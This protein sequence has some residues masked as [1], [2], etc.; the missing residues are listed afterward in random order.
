MVDVMDNDETMG[1]AFGTLA[2]QFVRNYVTPEIDAYR[3][4]KYAETSGISAATPPT[5]PL[6]PRTCPP[7]FR[8]PRAP[9]ATTRFPRRAEILFISENAYA[10][11]KDKITRMVMNGERGH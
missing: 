3:F 4:A 7:S 1:M 11:L 2:G 10:G 9:W 8:L 5:S 6:A